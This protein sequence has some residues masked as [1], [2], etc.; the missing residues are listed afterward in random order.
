MVGSHLDSV[1]EGPGLN[2]NGSGSS[3]TLQVALQYAARYAAA[4]KASAD[5]KLSTFARARFGWW[6][7]EEIG[8]LGS[9]FYVN[10]LVEN[11]TEFEKVL[12]PAK[13]MRAELMKTEK[14]IQASLDQILVCQRELR[15]LESDGY[16]SSRSSSINL[17]AGLELAQVA[18]PDSPP[19]PAVRQPSCGCC[20]VM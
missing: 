6:G 1:P 18:T 13:E 20:A 2:D 3:S 9:N 4:L 5:N 15:E 12:G 17:S 11:P 10:S 14:S 8:L 19:V 16:L 7:A